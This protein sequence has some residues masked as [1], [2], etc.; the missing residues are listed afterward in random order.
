[1]MNNVESSCGGLIKQWCHSSETDPVHRLSRLM[2]YR[3]GLPL[4]R[5]SLKLPDFVLHQI[6]LKCLTLCKIPST[7]V[8]CQ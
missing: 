6:Y 3:G 1:M 8:S 7:S 4:N 5:Q 2:F